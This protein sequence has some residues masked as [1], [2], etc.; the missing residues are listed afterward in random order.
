[1]VESPAHPEDA[2]QGGPGSAF[3]FTASI[4][5]IIC[6]LVVN[7]QMNFLMDSKLGYDRDQVVLLVLLCELGRF[8]HQLLRNGDVFG[9]QRKRMG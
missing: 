8:A 6:A 3:Q 2:R 5:L 9:R 7:K 4:I 1:M